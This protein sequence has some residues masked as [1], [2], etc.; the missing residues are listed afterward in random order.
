MKLTMKHFPLV[1]LLCT[2]LLFSQDYG[3][4][5]GTITDNEAFH[6]PLLFAD[7]TLKNP[8][9]AQRTTQTNFHGNFEFTQVAPGSYTLVVRYLGYEPLEMP[10]HIE[11]NQVIHLHKGLHAKRIQADPVVQAEARATR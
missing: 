9:Q 11:E 8:E 6:E 3:S 4:V 1:L 10:I 7:I 2:G 5:K